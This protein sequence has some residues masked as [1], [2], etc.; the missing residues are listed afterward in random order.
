MRKFRIA[1]PDDYQKVIKTLDCFDLLKGHDI[2]IIH[3]YTPNPKRLAAKLNDPDILVLTRTRTKVNKALLQ[4]LPNLKFISQTGKNAGHIDIADCKKY[5]VIVAE[6]RGNPI[7]TAELTWNLIMNGLRLVPQAIEGMKAGHWQVNMGRRI[8]GKRIGIWGYGKI[9]KRVAQYVKTFGAEVMV[10]GSEG[11]RQAASAD[12]FLAAA[13]KVEFFTT[14]DVVTLHLR[15]KEA[16][17]EIVKLSDLLMMKTDA[18][19]VNTARAALL[20]KG[21]LL[22]ALQTGRPGFAAIDVYDEEP[23]FDKNY[24]L[25]QLSNVICTPHLGYVERAGYELYFSTAFEHVLDF[26]KKEE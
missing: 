18:L 7:A 17:R 5:D 19:L 21:A 13:S 8:Y 11:S 20:E 9:G 25:L 3:D 23:I 15:L 12:G 22:Q 2:T 26:I 10:W 1:I 4:H 16:T 6:G 24:L 14:C